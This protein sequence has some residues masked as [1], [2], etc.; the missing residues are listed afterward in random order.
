MG[1]WKKLFG[2]NQR[3]QPE[4]LYQMEISNTNIKVTHPKRNDEQINWNE[5]EEIKLV[6]MDEGPFLPDVWLILMGNGK[7]CSIPQGS[8]GWNKVYD[9]VSNYEGFNF[10]NVIKSASCADNKTFDLWKR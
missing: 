5:I 10:E 1:V 9:I 3:Q 7:G 4:E 8:E 2:V 6:N